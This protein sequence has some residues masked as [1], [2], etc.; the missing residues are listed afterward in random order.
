MTTDQDA[1][2]GLLRHAARRVRDDGRLELQA[3]LAGAPA[4]PVDVGPLADLLVAAIAH[5]EPYEG[6]GW[7]EQKIL[8]RAPELARAAVALARAIVS[9]G[10]APERPIDSVSGPS[11]DTSH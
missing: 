5:V 2:T 10:A 4:R 3:V 9:P 7:D 1:L 11:G 6:R 8:D